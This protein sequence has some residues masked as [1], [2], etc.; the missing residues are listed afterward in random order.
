M[1]SK[2]KNC[3]ERKA[4]HLSLKPVWNLW[5]PSTYWYCSI[6]EYSFRD[7]T[8]E[9]LNDDFYRYQGPMTLSV[10]IYI[11]SLYLA[12]PQ[13][14]FGVRL[15]GIQR[16]E[17]VTNEPQ[18]TSAGRLLCTGPR[19]GSVQYIFSTG[20]KC[21][22]NRTLYNTQLIQFARIP[23]E[24]VVRFIRYQYRMKVMTFSIAP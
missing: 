12:S 17:C 1:Y 6:E 8:L 18:R 23:V 13:T 22:L 9:K 14:S 11:A 2:S 10:Q 5:K 19:Y 15:S 24:F 7:S 20:K 16:N 3:K 4:A 21:K